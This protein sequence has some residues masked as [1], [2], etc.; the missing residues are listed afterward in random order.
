MS[1]NFRLEPNGYLYLYHWIN[2]DVPFKVS[3]KVKLKSDQWNK[4]SQQPV[5]PG[6]KDVNN[7]KVVDTLAKYRTALTDAIAECKV[8]RKNL[9]STFHTKLSGEIIRGGTSPIRFLAFYL[10][11]I[12]EYKADGKSNWT[13]FKTTY[14]KLVRFFG[15]LRPTLDQIDIQFYR[16]FCRYMEKENLKVGSIATNWNNIKTI[17]GEAYALKL[18]AN[19]DYKQFKPIQSKDKYEESVHIYLSIPELEKI[20]DLNFKNH[21]DLDVTR[22]LFI[23]GANT[24][25]RF[26]DWHKISSDMV[27]DG[28]ITVTAKKTNI[29]SVILC[30]KYV[31]AILKKYNGTLPKLTNL[32]QVNTDLRTIGMVARINEIVEVNPKIG[33]KKLDTPLRVKKHTLIST[34]TARRSLATN[35]IKSGANPYFVMK[36]TGHKSIVS[37]SK[38]VKLEDED[39]IEKLKGLVMFQ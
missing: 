15:R 39:A 26:S 35:C 2:S 11:T 3:T 8:T 16:D 25:L 31:L 34:H 30:N 13:S 29:K 17:C 9:K 1:A 18:T 33:G 4:I 32:K 19:L 6:L 37:L 28:I 20:Y 14:N 24:G 5:D 21:P 38:Y 23:I 22:D 7:I 10:K 36:I 27:K 12:E